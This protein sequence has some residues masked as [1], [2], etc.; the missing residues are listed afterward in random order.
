[1]S[2]SDTFSNPL[3]V[4][5]VMVGYGKFFNPSKHEKLFWRNFGPFAC[6]LIPDNLLHSVTHGLN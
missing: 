5:V 3:K 6:H 1:M 4:F 2:K